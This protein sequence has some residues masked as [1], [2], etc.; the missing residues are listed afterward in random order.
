MLGESREVA[1]RG[2]GEAVWTFADGTLT[3][4]RTF[5]PAHIEPISRSRMAL[6]G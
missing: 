2:G 5:P 1:S 3:F 6:P 4:V